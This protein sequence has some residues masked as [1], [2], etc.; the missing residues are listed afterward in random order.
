MAGEREMAL[1]EI[2]RLLEG[3]YPPN[4][5]RMVQDAR[6]DFFR[7]D[8]RFNELIRPEGAEGP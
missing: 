8:E 2:E 3:P 4:K 5:W 1:A 6:W 7:D